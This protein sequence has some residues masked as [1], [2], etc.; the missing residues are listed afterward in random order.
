MPHSKHT[1][2]L[3]MPHS[4]FKHALTMLH[5]KHTLILSYS[6]HVHTMLKIQ[7]ITIQSLQCHNLHRPAW[8]PAPSMHKSIYTR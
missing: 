1:L 3:T 8:F 5:S 4:S 7:S 2:S 6:K